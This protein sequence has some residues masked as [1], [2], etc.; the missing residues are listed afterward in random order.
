MANMHL[1]A[2]LVIM[3]LVIGGIYCLH[4]LISYYLSYLTSASKEHHVIITC[5]QGS[6]VAVVNEEIIKTQDGFLLRNILFT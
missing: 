6:H 1:V 3:T 4:F 2:L 5:V